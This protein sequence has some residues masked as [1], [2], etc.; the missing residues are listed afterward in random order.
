MYIREGA[1]IVKEWNLPNAA[2]NPLFGLP[3]LPKT[4]LPEEPFRFLRRYQPEHAEIFFGRSNYIRQLHDRITS[5]IAAPVILFYGQSG[6]GKSSTLDS[7][8]LPRLQQE[9]DVKYIR[10]NV[11]IGLLGTFDEALGGNFKDDVSI[12]ISYARYGPILDTL[13]L[14]IL[15]R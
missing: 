14:F 13:I 8:L 6:A 11:H 9:A 1:E 10:R 5:E 12:C 15:Q 7:G 2:K 3:E 4:N